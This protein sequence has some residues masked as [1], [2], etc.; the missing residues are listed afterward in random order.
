MD[1]SIS[2][3]AIILLLPFYFILFI[4]ASID[5]G[6][7]GIFTQERVGRF[8]RSF[9]IYKFQTYHSVSHQKTNFGKWMR[10]TKL[11]ELPQL[12]NIL[13]GEMSIVGPRP[14]I[15]G[16][17]DLLEGENRLVLNLKPGIISKAG[18]KY[19]NEDDILDQKENPLKYNDEVLFPDKV[20]MNLDYY[21]QMSFKNDVQIIW[22]AAKVILK[23][24]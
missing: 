8:G 12:F 24:N 4:L 10:K 1:F 20:R 7:P 6:F 16:Y 19:R 15:K 2:F 22:E 11:D 5:T 18:L 9:T 23:L 3:V 17:Y 21:N 13:K 14:D